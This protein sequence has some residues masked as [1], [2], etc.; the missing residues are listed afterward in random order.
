MLFAFCFVSVGSTA[1][2]YPVISFHLFLIPTIYSVLLICTIRFA[3]A[4]VSVLVICHGPLQGVPSKC[5]AH[6]LHPGSLYPQSATPA[7]LQV[8]EEGGT[9]DFPTVATAQ[10][11]PLAKLLFRIPG[12][13]SVFL[14][15]NFITVTKVRRNQDNTH[16]HKNPAWQRYFRHC[17]FLKWLRNVDCG[18][19]PIV[20]QIEIQCGKE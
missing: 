4:A 3:V 6:R 19:T 18:Y 9:L 11:S 16:S 5:W 17:Q 2:Y 10:H 7:F 12:V 20:F 13:K 1:I 8:L 15:P 14:A